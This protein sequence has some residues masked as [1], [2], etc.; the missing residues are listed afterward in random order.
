[1]CHGNKVVKSMDFL[2]AVVEK[3]VKDGHVYE[4]SDAGDEF[5]N[6]ATSTINVKVQVLPHKLFERDGDN[7]KT[8]VYLTLEEALLGFEKSIIHLDG[9]EVKLNKSGVT[10]PGDKQKILDEGM[11]HHQFSSEFG[12][13]YVTYEVEFPTDLSQNRLSKFRKMFDFK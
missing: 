13:L 11:P 5:L 2:V 10:N 4:N 1:V 9:H 8:K 3:G 7:L 12:D 6:V